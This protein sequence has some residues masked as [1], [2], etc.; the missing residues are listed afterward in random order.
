MKTKLTSYCFDTNRVEQDKIDH[1][2]LYDELIK[3]HYFFNVL[4][5][6]RDK[7]ITS[8][9]VEFDTTHIFSNQWNTTNGLRVHEWYEPIY[10]NKGLKKGYYLELTDEMK[11]LQNK[12]FSC[13]Y[14]GKQTLIKSDFCDQ[15]IDS[16]Y[17][18]LNELHLLR[19]KPVSF[20]GNREELSK[21]ELDNLKPLFLKYQ[22]YRNKKKTDE[23]KVKLTKDKDA[24]IK[25]A[26]TEYNGFLWLIGNNIN[27]DNCIYYSHT[28]KF[29]FGWRDQLDQELVDKFKL[30]LIT[31]PF[32]YEF[33]VTL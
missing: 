1:Q 13:G 29:C 6:T 10:P 33:K 20:T 31:F 27:T 16:S 19:M 12:T 26:T 15:C 3:T 11:D 8:Q 14:C 30:L 22:T 9:I 32:N 23:L 4:G 7:S 25:R 28:N 17:L 5:N 24:R 2:I 18:S 21:S